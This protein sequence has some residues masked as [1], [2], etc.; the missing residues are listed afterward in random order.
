MVTW[1]WVVWLLAGLV[2]VGLEIH[3]QA[4]Y[5]LFLALGAFVATIVALFPDEV[6][7][8]AVAAAG[9]ALLGTLLVRPTLVR[10]SARHLGPKLAM[11][12]ASDNLVGQPALTLEPV[13]DEN[14]PGHARLF[15]EKWLAV[16]TNPGGVP[17]HT[18][19]T[20]VEVRGTTL[21]V[22]PPRGV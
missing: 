1:M 5:S 14:H 2:L 12:G 22:A 9:V 20:V 6:W 8:Q 13:G 4:F 10:I 15:N 17:A 3:T 16:T 7:V 18:Q 21:V 19:V 11:P